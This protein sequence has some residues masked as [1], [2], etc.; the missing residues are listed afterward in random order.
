M[1][2]EPKKSLVEL[3]KANPDR[4]I[5]LNEKTGEYEVE[6]EM[7]DQEIA[8]RL[9]ARRAPK[10]IEKAVQDQK[11]KHGKRE[12][13]AL[14][15]HKRVDEYE[16]EHQDQSASWVEVEIRKKHKSDPIPKLPARPQVLLHIYEVRE[17]RK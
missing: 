6:P 13:R 1:A 14:P 7:T 4:F 9:E 11:D 10:A 12:N 16:L 2:K 15:W 8:L 17:A 3:C 5:R